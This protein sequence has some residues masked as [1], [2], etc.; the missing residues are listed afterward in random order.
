[1]FVSFK[2]NFFEKISGYEN[3][4][5]RN[6]CLTLRGQKIFVRHHCLNYWIAKDFSVDFDLTKDISHLCHMPS[7]VKISHLNQESRTVNNSRK[8][9]ATNSEC[10]GHES[11]PD[12]VL[13][14]ICHFRNPKLS[15]FWRVI[16]VFQVSG[17]P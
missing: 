9:C 2:C 12:C 10:T 13:W 1:M 14:N 11:E 17:P 4:K 3:S 5:Y 6:L 16:S 7:C 8:I 15:S